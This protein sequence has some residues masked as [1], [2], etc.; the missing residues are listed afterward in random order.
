MFSWDLPPR[1]ISFFSRR[2]KPEFGG[3]HWPGETPPTMHHG[4]VFP[5]PD[6]SCK[7]EPIIPRAVA[8]FVRIHTIVSPAG[9]PLSGYA[10][11]W[12]RGTDTIACA[13]PWLHSFTP[14]CAYSLIHS[15]TCTLCV[16]LYECLCVFFCVVWEVKPV[17][18]SKR[19]RYR[20]RE[21]RGLRGPRVRGSAHK[22]EA[23]PGRTKAKSWGAVV[24][25]VVVVVAEREGRQPLSSFFFFFKTPALGSL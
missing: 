25:L 7:C 24:V 10:S 9:W 15:H 23:V 13:E 12:I 1:C 3:G 20:S 19:G 8:A 17:E 18:L 11:N 4:I 14:Y 5:W 2:K 6:R 22:R 16:S 21:P